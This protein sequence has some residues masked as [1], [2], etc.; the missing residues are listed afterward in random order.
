[1]NDLLPLLEIQLFYMLQNQILQL[2]IRLAL[3]SSNRGIFMKFRSSWV[4]HGYV[5]NIHMSGSLDV[6]L[7][8]KKPVSVIVV[9]VSLI[10]VLSM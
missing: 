9:H 7:E 8:V 3:R 6:N 4:E 1:M 2:P 10:L 5:R